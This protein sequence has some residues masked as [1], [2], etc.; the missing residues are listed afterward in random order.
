VTAPSPQGVC[1]SRWD[2]EWNE[3]GEGD[4]EFRLTYAGPLYAHNESQ[5]GPRS[6]KTRHKHA[7]RKHF[8]KQLK[9]LWQQHP[10]LLGLTEDA[11]QPE[12]IWK[13]YSRENII[14]QPIVRAGMPSLICRLD[15]MMLRHG[16]KGGVLGDIDNRLKTLFDALQLVERP[17]DLPT[18]PASGEPVKAT[19]DEKPFYVLLENDRLIT[20]IS[21]ET[22]TLLEP[23]EDPETH[24]EVP[25]ENAVRLVISVTVR[26]YRVHWDNLG[27][28]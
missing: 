28:L 8:H 7:L 25:M 16:G 19:D 2:P 6:T 9:G 14:W 4:M 24:K 15:I 20:A 26:P 17:G 23:V 21:V 11:Q 3:P 1:V 27:L 22:D 18:D 10:V 12:S 13:P 5:T